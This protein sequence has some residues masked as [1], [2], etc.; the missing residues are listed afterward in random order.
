MPIVDAALA[1][2]WSEGIKE[3]FEM[4]HDKDAIERLGIKTLPAMTIDDEIILEGDY[5]GLEDMVVLL[6]E[7]L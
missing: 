4:T 6:R 1:R 5:P 2:L 3:K 7:K